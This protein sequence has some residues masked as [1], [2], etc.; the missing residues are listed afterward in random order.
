MERFVSNVLSLLSSNLAK[1]RPIFWAC[2]EGHVDVV[3]LLVERGG[4]GQLQADVGTLVM[5]RPIIFVS[6]TR[7]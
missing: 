3:K 4:Q 7:K 2:T 5:K 1:D 6:N